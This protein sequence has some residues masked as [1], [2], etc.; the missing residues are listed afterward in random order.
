MDFCELGGNSCSSLLIQEINS[1]PREWDNDIRGYKPVPL[2]SYFWKEFSGACEEWD[3]ASEYEVRYY[4]YFVIYLTD[5]QVEGIGE[6]L[7]SIGFSRT[8]SV[9]AG[10]TGNMCSLWF[11][12][13]SMVLAHFRKWQKSL[14]EGKTP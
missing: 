11:A 7:Q 3:E 10:K 6:F 2:E 9:R 8:P 12:E 4:A 5:K 13:V 1:N 14:K